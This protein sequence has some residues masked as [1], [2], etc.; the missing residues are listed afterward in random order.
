M[1]KRWHQATLRTPHPFHVFLNNSHPPL[2]ARLKAIRDYHGKCYN[3]S[4]WVAQPAREKWLSVACH[5]VFCQQ[6]SLQLFARGWVALGLIHTTLC[7]I[8]GQGWLWPAETCVCFACTKYDECLEVSG[9]L[10]YTS[11]YMHPAWSATHFHCRFAQRGDHAA[12]VS[13]LSAEAH[14]FTCVDSLC[15]G[16]QLFLSTE[17]IKVLELTRIHLHATLSHVISCFLA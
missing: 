10:V 6:S 4:M 7:G 1:P 12:Y 13:H 5:P 8:Y 14:T 2:D 16:H 11:M 15:E 9:I 3:E 17:F